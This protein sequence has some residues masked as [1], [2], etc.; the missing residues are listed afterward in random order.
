MIDIQLIQDFEEILSGDVSW[1]ERLNNKKLLITG[2][3]GLIGSIIGRLILHYNK[4]HGGHIFIICQ[5][6]NIEKAKNIY[7]DYLDSEYIDFCLGD[8]N[9]TIVYEKPIDYIIHCANTTSSRAYVSEPVETI[10]TI[11]IGTDNM[12][13]FALQKKV[14]SF[15]YL[16]SMETYGSPYYENRRIT[17]DDSGYINTMSVRSSYSEGKR[18]AECLCASYASEY[19]L[20]I[21]VARLAQVFGAGV[22]PKDNRVFSQL[23]KS[24]INKEDF[25][26]H[27]DGESYGNY[28]YTTDAAKAILMLLTDGESGEA[29]N[30]VNESNCVT[31]KEMAE[32]VAHEIAKDSF[33]VVY[34]IPESN[35]TYGY[36]PKVVMRLSSKKM[37]SL[38]WKATVSL[39]DMYKRMI[40]S[41]HFYLGSGNMLN[42]Q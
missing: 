35:L 13:Q 20:C 10:R 16:S 17:E 9:E 25:I 18:I 11:T 14:E 27:S 19:G 7:C 8:I 41:L 34:D 2:S 21:K 23:A 40:K 29:Y 26:M 22:N 6:R 36:A 31:I 38:G 5:V 42:E 3:T 30:V 12:L 4:E 15:V 39:P 1:I 24:V 37:N 28:C 33:K 32:M